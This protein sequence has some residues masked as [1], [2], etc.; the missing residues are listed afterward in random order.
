MFYTLK[1]FEKKKSLLSCIEKVPSLVLL[2]ATRGYKQKKIS[3]L[4]IVLKVS[5]SL[6]RGGR[7]QEAQNIVI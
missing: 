4:L 5:R 7:L 3:N 6:T 2:K 1:S